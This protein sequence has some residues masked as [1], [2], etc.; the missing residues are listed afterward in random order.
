MLEMKPL[1]GSRTTNRD[2]KGKPR[3]VRR[4]RRHQPT[5]M[6]RSPKT[7]ET[8]KLQQGV[9]TPIA[10]WVS[11][12]P[13]N[14]KT[15]S[16]HERFSRFVEY[17]K[18]DYERANEIE[19]AWRAIASSAKSDDDLVTLFAVM[20]D[21]PEAQLF[22]AIY[23]KRAVDPSGERTRY[24]KDLEAVIQVIAL[25]SPHGNRF[26]ELMSD[27]QTTEEAFE[28]AIKL[29]SLDADLLHCLIALRTLLEI[30]DPAAKIPTK[31]FLNEEIAARKNYVILVASLNRYLSKPQHAALAV[32]AN[33]NCPG[34]TLNND[35]IR[36]AW[37]RGADKRA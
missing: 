20:P 9:P 34:A 18:R 24:D 14:G 35:Q 17:W 19:K 15:E 10:Q 28:A 3:P 31:H 27:A 25:V 16:Y 21:K 22:T 2:H 23:G 11:S 1:T 30:V 5:I 26:D 37:N 29:R 13:K 7:N 36:K 4:V 32:I 6:P 33:V 12:L 8:K